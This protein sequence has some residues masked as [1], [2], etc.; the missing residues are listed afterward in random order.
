MTLYASADDL[1]YAF[2]NNN[3]LD[4]L[5]Y[6]TEYNTT[7]ITDTIQGNFTAG[8]NTL[9]FAVCNS[10]AGPT[11]LSFAADINYDTG[12][13]TPVSEPVTMLLLGLGLVGLAGVRRKFKT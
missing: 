2:L 3:L 8:T 4:P 6:I 12:K 11:G 13:G 7:G 10:G 1:A 5:M 9:L